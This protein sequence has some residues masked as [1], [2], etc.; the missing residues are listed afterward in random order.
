MSRGRRDNSGEKCAPRPDPACGLA[1]ATTR[2][3]RAARRAT[4]RSYCRPGREAVDKTECRTT[5]RRGERKRP[6]QRRVAI[7]R[8]WSR[9][10]AADRE[11]LGRGDTLDLSDPAARAG[12]QGPCGVDEMLERGGDFFP[13]ARFE[14]AIGVHP[15][16]LAGYPPLRCEEQPAH[17]FGGRHSWGVDVIDAGTDLV[18][19]PKCWKALRRSIC[20]RGPRSR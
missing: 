20:D 1:P 4:R 10:E 15:Q 7:R 14:P 11:Q 5:P 17:L 6:D 16:P 19:V 8:P 13:S 2:S 18:R 3:D 9:T 12:A